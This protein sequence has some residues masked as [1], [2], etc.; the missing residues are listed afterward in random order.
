[1]AKDLLKT[2]KILTSKRQKLSLIEVRKYDSDHEKAMDVVVDL[3]NQYETIETID[4][5]LDALDEVEITPANL[6]YV[7]GLADCL[8][9]LDRL[10]GMLRRKVCHLVHSAVL[11]D[12]DQYR[13]N[14]AGGK[15][16]TVD[17]VF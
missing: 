2:M 6:A 4:D 11:V 17:T 10:A 12:M 8:L 7:A 5:L 16:E 1:M 3:Q 9:I 14:H 13:L 15:L